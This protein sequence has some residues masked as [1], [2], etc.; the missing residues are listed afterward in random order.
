MNSPNPPPTS[1]GSSLGLYSE[2]G[3]AQVSKWVGAENP[4]TPTPILECQLWLCC[5]EKDRKAWSGK[6][7]ISPQ[8]HHTWGPTN[9]DRP[10]V[11]VLKD[12][13]QGIHGNPKKRKTLHQ[14]KGSLENNFL[15]DVGSS[16]AEQPGY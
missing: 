7:R 6:F 11:I 16:N 12:R 15:N 2:D 9:S 4:R 1:G 5:T 10:T 14:N 13:Q 3:E 8:K